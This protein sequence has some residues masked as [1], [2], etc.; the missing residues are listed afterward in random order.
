MR[1][2]GIVLLVFGIMG[3]LQANSMDTSVPTGF[4]GMRL[5]NIGLMNS[6]QNAIIVS[7]IISIIGLILVVNNKKKTDKP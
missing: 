3:L 7:G 6:K 1:T 4:F 2:F 5:N